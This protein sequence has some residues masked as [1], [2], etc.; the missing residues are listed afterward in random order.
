MPPIDLTTKNLAG[1]RLWLLNRGRGEET[2]RVYMSHLKKCME[3]ERVTSRLLDK[4]LAPKTR[5]A[6]QSA[7][8]SWAKYAKNPDMAEAIEEIKLPPAI[9]VKPK[10]ELAEH[11]WSTVLRVLNDPQIEKPW[12]GRFDQGRHR[13]K[14]GCH[15]I[16]RAARY[17][18]LIVGVRGLRMGDALRISRSDLNEALA[19]GKLSFES[20]GGRR[21]EYDTKTIKP[22]LS[23][24]ALLESWSVTRDLVAKPHSSDRVVNATLRRALRKVAIAAKVADVHPHRLRRTYATHFIRRLKNDPQALVKLMKHMGWTNINTA[25]MYTDSVN[26]EELD[27]L[28]TDLMRDVMG[29]PPDL[30]ALKR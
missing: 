3:T 17:L 30:R 21:L 27:N 22:Y 13:S 19:T 28:S 6:N 11:D 29:D 1:F 25:A 4:K 9:R 5:R 23:E 15:H 8:L 24:L 20:K 2:A 14:Y 10:Q 7:L 26:V 12:S 16:T 18:L